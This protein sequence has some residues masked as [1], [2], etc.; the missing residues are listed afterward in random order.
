MGRVESTRHKEDRLIP[1]TS[2]ERELIADVRKVGKIRLTG[3]PT[4]LILDADILFPPGGLTDALLEKLRSLAHDGMR[5]NL[6]T[7][8]GEEE[9]RERLSVIPNLYF[10][11]PSQEAEVSGPAIAIV[12][13]HQNLPPN[14]YA[15]YVGERNNNIPQGMHSSR[16]T[17]AEGADRILGLFG[18]GMVQEKASAAFQAAG[19]GQPLSESYPYDSA[20]LAGISTVVAPMTLEHVKR[21]SEH[22]VVELA[23]DEG[24]A[25]LIAK[26][27]PAILASCAENGAIA[28]AARPKTE[29]DPNYW[30]FWQRDAGQIAL[31]LANLAKTSQYQK[32]QEAFRQRAQR[33]VSFV[34][35]LSERKDILGVSRCKMNGTPVVTYGNPQNDGPAHTALAAMNI[36]EDK[37]EDAYRIAKPYL[38]FLTTP[39][40]SG[41]TFDPWEFSVGEIFNALNLARRALRQGVLRARQHGG[42]TKRYEDH[43][44][45]LEKRLIAFYDKKKK[46]LVSGKNLQIPWMKTTS[47]LDISVI[48]SVLTA[49]DVTDDFMNVDDPR[50]RQTMTALEKAFAEK[51]PV[52]VAWQKAGNEGMGMGRFPEDTNDGKGSTGG[53]PWTFATL[54][55]SQY[56]FR[57]IQRYNHLGKEDS[58][59]FAR[60]PLQEKA[61][62]YL[63]FVLAHVPVNEL[64]EQID[65][66]TGQPRGANKLAWAHAELI[67]TL[68]LRESLKSF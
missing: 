67:N 40:G 60:G 59:E 28:A 35:R 45:Q 17:G 6:I 29:S 3:A 7:R 25:R 48:G 23:S 22:Q 52:N 30:F 15:W 37:P 66:Q 27:Y 38:D 68:L 26:A 46:Y 14:T 21:D 20:I 2:S 61:E 34:A 41:L 65:G 57:L 31:A 43:E 8:S 16:M 10:S 63:K 51:W 1:R 33:Y 13:S 39:E 54:W 9:L 12:S 50:V 42:D 49:Y 44:K 5:I 62:G 58:G 56:Y 4:T 19:A 24:T 18:T 32:V 36:L 64:T 47:N 55:A 53:N 11:L